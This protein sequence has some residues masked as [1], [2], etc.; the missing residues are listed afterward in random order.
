MDATK[1]NFRDNSFDICVDKGTYDALAVT[2][3][4]LILIQ[5][6]PN[7]E[8]LKTLV[9]EMVRVSSK[10]VVIISSGTPEK[11][12]KFLEEY[13]DY[14]NK[15]EHFELELSQLAQ[16]INILRTNMKDKPLSHALKDKEIF[17]KAIKESKI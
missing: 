9:Q 6:G 5:C 1:M 3:I 10:A 15:I 7:R 12:L 16:L 17:G 14:N 2:F 11:R 8:I 4:I 13:T